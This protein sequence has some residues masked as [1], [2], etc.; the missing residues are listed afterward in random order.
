MICTTKKKTHTLKKSTEQ[1]KPPKRVT[2]KLSEDIFVSIK[3]E[4]DPKP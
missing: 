2:G 1:T 3:S 4:E